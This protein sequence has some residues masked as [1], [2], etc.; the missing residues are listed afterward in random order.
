MI[1]VFVGTGKY[2]ETTD[3]TNTQQ[4]TL[5][6]IKD[7]NASATL[8]NPRTTLVGQTLTVAGAIRTA[9]NNAVDFTTGRGWFIDL[10]DSGE[11]QNVASQLVSG[12]LLVP[13]TVPSATV[14][15][16]GGYSWFNY[17]NASTGGGVTSSNIVSSKLNSPIVGFNVVN[18]DTDGDGASETKSV[19]V[20]TAGGEIVPPCVGP[21]CDLFAG[22]LGAFK[23]KRA[24]WR[25]FIQ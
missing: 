14:C 8:V 6:A 9:T 17:F 16:P 24:I 23:G 2:L 12:T 22:S 4:Q 21:D 15:S 18:I 13:T 20:V 7:D 19:N 10:P 25:E 3:L 11:R 1:V 5:Y